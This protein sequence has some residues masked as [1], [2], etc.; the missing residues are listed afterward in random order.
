MRTKKCATPVFISTKDGPVEIENPRE[1]QFHPDGRF[2]IHRALRI[3]GARGIARWVL[4]HADSGMRVGASHKGRRECLEV[5]RKRCR[6]LMGPGWEEPGRMKPYLDRA[7]ARRAK[8]AK[9]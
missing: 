3:P 2:V 6:Q 8:G 4:T 9:S 7:M 1:V 5:A